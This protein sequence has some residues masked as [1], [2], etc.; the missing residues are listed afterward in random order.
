EFDLQLEDCLLLDFNEQELLDVFRK[1]EFRSLINK[2]PKSI[3]SKEETPQ[4][5]LFGGSISNNA[6][7]VVKEIESL[8]SIKGA[9]RVVFYEIHD[10][11]MLV[12]YVDN[13]GEVF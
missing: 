1:F 10:N 4:L 11:Y 6:Q 9:I 5:D 8:E 2:I 13:L 12:S 3:N 7:S